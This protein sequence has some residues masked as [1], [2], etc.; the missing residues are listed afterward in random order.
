MRIGLGYD[1]HRLVPDRDLI[2]GGVTLPYHLGEEA[3]SDGDV[4]IHALI[5]ALFGALALGDIGT[6]FPPNDNK[7]KDISSSI[8]L[9]KCYTM[10]EEKGF[11]I[12]NID[13]TVILEKPKIKPHVPQITQKLSTLLKIS[14]E[15]ISIKGKTKEGVDSVGENKAIEAHVIVLLKRKNK[16]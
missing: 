10:I 1:L 7:W 15:Q 2:I 16:P 11:E 8:L 4:L 3:H 13:S 12:V 9:E 5:D 14:P 6:H